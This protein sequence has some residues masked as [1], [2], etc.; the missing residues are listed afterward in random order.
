MNRVFNH[1]EINMLI[2]HFYQDGK[3]L[4]MKN[5]YLLGMFLVASLS[6]ATSLLLRAGLCGAV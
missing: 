1:P 4:Y 2:S 6:L 3:Q 5:E